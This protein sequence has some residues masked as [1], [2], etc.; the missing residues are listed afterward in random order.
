MKEVVTNERSDAVATT[1]ARWSAQPEISAR[2]VLVT[3]FGDSVLPVTRSLWLSQLF[4]LT[5][6]FGFNDRLVRTSMYRLAAEGWLTNERVGRQSCYHLT[7]LAVRESEHAATRIY[8]ATPADWS[9]TWSLVLLDN[10]GLEAQ[11]QATLTA[12][13][14]WHGFVTLGRGLLGSP[15]ATTADVRELC[16]LLRPTVHVPVASA[17]FDG[18]SEL[19]GGGFFSTGFNTPDIASVYTSFVELYEPIERD[20]PLASSIDAFALRTMLVHDIRRIRLR[21][22]DIPSQLL[23]PDW[24]GDRA[25]EIASALYP[26]LSASAAPALSEVFDLTYPEMLPT[27]FA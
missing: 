16:D 25:D 24:I 27:R 21:F 1:I 20:A 3:I 18:M 15:T 17:S 8:D 7:E 5:D 23:P 6:V 13:L 2:S 4:Q 10:S 26:A 9:G 14:R 11:E 22:P 19:V 12:H